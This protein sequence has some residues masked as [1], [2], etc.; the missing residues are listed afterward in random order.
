MNNRVINIICIYAGNHAIKNII[1]EFK[2]SKKFKLLGIHARSERRLK[3]LKEIYT[4][5]IS[6]N[7]QEI[8]ELKNYDAVYISS[9]PSIHYQLSKKFL[10]KNKH[11]L[12][13]KPAVI[14]FN[15]AKSLISYTKNNRLAIMECFMYRFHDQFR[16]LKILLVNEKI[17]SIDASFGFPH[18]SKDD[19]RYKKKM[20]GGALL[21]AGCYPI[22]IIQFLIG[23]NMKLEN[24]YFNKGRYE[25]DIF[26]KANFISKSKLKF[27]ANWYFGGKYV[28]RL[29]IKTSDKHLIVDRAFS[30]PVDLKTSIIIEDQ[31]RNTIKVDKDNHF[32]NMIIY[33]YK[34]IFDIKIKKSEALLIKE[35]AKYINLLRSM[36]K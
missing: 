26:G 21:D 16:K 15:Q 2:K 24:Y 12:I 6:M 32:K 19:F 8:T 30:K 34:S 20:G 1:P 17:K 4:C 7:L 36:Q 27:K 35:Q 29:K 25:V 23:V 14:N 22:S 11:I 10:K 13:E 28:N 9:P 18:L 33:F 31:N 3:L 5:K